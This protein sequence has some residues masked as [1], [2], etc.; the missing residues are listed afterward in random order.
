MNENE[1]TVLR[2]YPNLPLPVANLPTREGKW[3]EIQSKPIVPQAVAQL[4]IS[5]QPAQHRSDRSR[6]VT[7]P[8]TGDRAMSHTNKPARE[9]DEIEMEL[10]GV[11]VARVAMSGEL[12]Q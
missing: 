9:L 5:L 2:A 12:S 1:L 4:A 11:T 10:K 7:R 8:G 3:P 6:V